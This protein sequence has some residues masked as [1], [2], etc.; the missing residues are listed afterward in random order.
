MRDERKHTE[1][2]PHTRRRNIQMRNLEHAGPL[3]G[4]RRQASSL[5]GPAGGP[6]NQE[7]QGNQENTRKNQENGSAN[8]ENQRKPMLFLVF[9]IGGRVFLIFPCVFLVF[10]VFL[11]FCAASQGIVLS[12]TSANTA[13][14]HICI[15]LSSTSANTAAPDSI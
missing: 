3:P 15:V 12:S 6:E 2:T 1:G 14:V 10:L 9:L 11:I 4:R 13:E 5:R 7:N 8:Q